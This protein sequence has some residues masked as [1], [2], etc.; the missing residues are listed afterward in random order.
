ME[1]EIKLAPVPGETGRRIIE[2]E[3]I[4]IGES[5]VIEMN[6]SYYDTPSRALKKQGR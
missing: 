2:S 1:I 5:S 6:A 3:P 4:Y